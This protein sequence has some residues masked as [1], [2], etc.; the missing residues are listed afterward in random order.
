MSIVSHWLQ[1]KAGRKL[2]PSCFFK[3]AKWRYLVI[4]SLRVIFPLAVSI[5]TL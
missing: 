2:I 1:K 4:S 3:R 5:V